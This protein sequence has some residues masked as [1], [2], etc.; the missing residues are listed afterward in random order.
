MIPQA[1]LFDQGLQVGKNRLGQPAEV[2]SALKNR[3]HSSIAMFLGQVPNQL[4]KIKKIF[5]DQLEMAERITLSESNPA[6]TMISSGLNAFILETSFSPKAI[7][8]IS[9]LP[10]PAGKGQLSVCPKPLPVPVSSAPPVPGYQGA[11]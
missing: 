4:S 8:S 6:E 11:W 2:I 10:A 3:N 5:I 9:F 7:S 1:C